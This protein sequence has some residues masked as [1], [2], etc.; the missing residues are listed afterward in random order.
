MLPLDKHAAIQHIIGGQMSGG[1][2]AIDY[3]SYTPAATL[4]YPALAACGIQLHAIG[5]T[6]N[7]Y[8]AAHLVGAVHAGVIVE[9]YLIPQ[10]WIEDGEKAAL[11]AL[12]RLQDWR[13]VIH[14]IWLDCETLSYET[15]H[16]PG[17]NEAW[18]LGARRTFE[19]V[20]IEVGLYSNMRMWNLLTQD[21][22]DEDWKGVKRWDAYYDGDPEHGYSGD[23]ADGGVPW[24][25]QYSG[26]RT[27]CG[28]NVDL[29]WCEGGESMTDAEIKE[30]VG[31]LLGQEIVTIHDL[32]A[33]KTELLTQNYLLATG[34]DDAAK[35]RIEFEA[36]AG[37][38]TL[39]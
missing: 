15:L 16:G 2:R 38:V 39:P 34:R 6:G 20:G 24:M 3:S 25:S 18:M 7:N 11:N 29:D 33:V 23:W 28:A 5:I 12:S 10:Y 26:S 19:R 14:R 37:K 9:P 17:T 36:A 8:L 35:Q 1:F 27:L 31:S 30:L 22:C 4:D 13:S 21:I 32:S